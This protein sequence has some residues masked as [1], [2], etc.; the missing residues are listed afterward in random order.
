MIENLKYVDAISFLNEVP[1]DGHSPLLVIANDFNAY[2]IKNTRG[3]NPA[4]FL[5]NEFLCHYLLR[6]WNIASPEIA[7]VTVDKNIL[8]D[9]LSNYH[10]L[11]YYDNIAFGSKKMEHVVEMNHFA[12]IESK[13]TFNKFKKPDDL[14]KLGLFD[15]WVENDDRKPTNPNVLFEILE[16]RIGIVAIDNAFTFCSLSY[17]QLFKGE[18]CQSFNDNL[19]YS[20][21]VQKIY[22]Y[23]KKENGRIDYIKDYFYLCINNCK[24]NYN[25]IIANIPTSLGLTQDLK[26]HLYDFLFDDER[27][28]LVLQNF[29]SRL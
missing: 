27:N 6:L 12:G 10:K 21:F 20:A 11:Y 1:T 2:Y 15:I 4:T 23:I 18:V 5:I 26:E 29:Y 16:D 9:T 24:A 7:A 8:P 17:D 3:H 14:L 13:T 25:D 28:H 22:E 19:L